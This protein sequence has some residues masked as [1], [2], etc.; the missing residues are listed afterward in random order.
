MAD[1]ISPHGGTHS[2]IGDNKK[3]PYLFIQ[4]PK[5]MVANYQ[6]PGLEGSMAASREH[7]V[8]PSE[9]PKTNFSISSGVLRNLQG[10]TIYLRKLEFSA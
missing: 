4:C 5:L 3:G 6:F 8:C 2:T 7:R 1:G 9:V 10:Y